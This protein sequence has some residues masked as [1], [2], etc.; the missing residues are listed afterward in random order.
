VTALPRNPHHSPREELK[1]FLRDREQ[2][3]H[4]VIRPALDK[5]EIVVLDRYY[6]STIA[7][8]GVRGFSVPSLQKL[9]QR[10]FIVPDAVFLL[11]MDPWLSVHRIQ[12]RGD[13]PNEFERVSNLEQAREIFLSLKDKRIIKVDGN[14][15]IA[16][17][18]KEVLEKFING[19]LKQRRCAKSYGCDDPLYCAYR[20]TDTCPW[21]KLQGRLREVL[22]TK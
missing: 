21:I 1:Y 22:V 6:Y 13:S 20:M 15:S 10:R 3:T 5:N 18:H 4:N 14:M 8:Q 19:P 11:D 16:S 9:M 12:K 7:Y 17:V 2:R